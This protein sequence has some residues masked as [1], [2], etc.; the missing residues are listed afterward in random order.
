[1]IQ[2]ASHKVG[3]LNQKLNVESATHESSNEVV[4][5]LCDNCGEDH[6]V[7]DCVKE[8]LMGEVQAI[9][10]NSY[11]GAPQTDTKVKISSLEETLT[12]FMLVRQTEFLKVNKL[13]NSLKNKH[14]ESMKIL[15]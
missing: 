4:F 2:R 8:Q 12:Q 15:E 11:Q 3:R 14:E 7:G 13:Q 9:I 1:M 5:V 6:F 10:M